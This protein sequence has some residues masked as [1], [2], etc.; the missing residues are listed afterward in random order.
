MLVEVL[1]RRAG[2]EA[3]HADEDAVRADHGVPAQ[4]HGGLDRDL[5]RGVA[6]DGLA[7][8]VRLRQEELQR[9]HRDDAR[10]DAALGQLLLRGD[11]DLDLRAGGEDRHLGLAGSAA[12]SS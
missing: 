9:R 2:A 6:D 3:V 5:H 8:L 11:R 1:V 12:T 7:P 4:A 10:G